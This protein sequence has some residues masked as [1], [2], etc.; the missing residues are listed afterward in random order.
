[1]QCLLL[2]DSTFIVPHVLSQAFG[3]HPVGISN[4][5]GDKAHF[6]L[7]RVRMQL[8]CGSAQVADLYWQTAADAIITEWV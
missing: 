5:R 7:Q 6:L 4:Q 2:M 3:L 8:C 1:M